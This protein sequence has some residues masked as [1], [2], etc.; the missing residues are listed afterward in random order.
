MATR[1]AEKEWK[2]GKKEGIEGKENR[3]DVCVCVRVCKCVG[4]QCRKEEDLRHLQSTLTQEIASLWLGG[5][6]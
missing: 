5:A 1:R 3:H 4:N 6:D 2:G